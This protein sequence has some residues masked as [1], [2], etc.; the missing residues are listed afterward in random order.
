M[1]QSNDVAVGGLV[2]LYFL[3]ETVFGSTPVS[4]TFSKARALRTGLTFAKDIYRSEERDSSRQRK[5]VRHGYHNVSGD[6]PGELSNTTWD[7]FIEAAMG[8]TFAGLTTVSVATLSVTTNKINGVGADF[9]TAG[10]KIGDIFVVDGSDGESYRLQAA[11]I[12]TTDMDIRASAGITSILT[13]ALVSLVGQKVSIGNSYRSFTILRHFTD[14]NLYQ[15]FKGCRINSMNFNVP[16]TG[17]LGVTFGLTGVT[18]GTLSSTT[19][20][21]ALAAAATTSP[22]VAVNGT[23]YEGTGTTELGIV[24][25]MTLNHANGMEATKVLGRNTSPHV[26]FGRFAEITGELTVL[27]DSVTHFNKFVNE[28]ETSLDLAV[29][30][31]N[32]EETG[33]FIRI[34]LARLKYSGGDID[35]GADTAIPIT[36][37]FEVLKPTGVT[38]GEE[39]SGVVIQRNNIA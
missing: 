5:D 11:S 13:S 38:T 1:P 9:V 16:P 6:I 37:P 17:I 28:T 25:G 18:G 39:T 10:F 32:N 19:V 26:I 34:R 21:S 20:A 3:E 36:L 14:L 7:A 4:T 31:S 15:D 29:Y 2:D 23:L 33:N 8:G 30:D 12:G 22:M 24:L 27:F 35:D